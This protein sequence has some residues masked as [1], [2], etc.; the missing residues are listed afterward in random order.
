[1]I[2][3]TVPY[4]APEQI[5]GQEAD[6]R[7]DIFA[8]GA[9][10]Y[11]MVTGQRAFQGKST[12]SLMSSILTINPLAP[13]RVLSGVPPALDHI[14]EQCLA[15]D[16]EERWHSARDLWLELKNAGDSPRA[17]QQAIAP[18]HDRRVWLL[19][20]AVAVLL[21]A[22]SLLAVLYFRAPVPATPSIHF[23]VPAVGNPY[24]LSISPDRRSLAYVAPAENGKSVLWVRA[25]SSLD[26][27]MLPGTE[28]ADVP[29]WSPDSRFIVFGADGK[30]K[31]VDVTG[32]SPQT[33]TNL[34]PGNH[35]R[36]AWNR[37]GV[38]LVANAGI[39][40]RVAA[41]GGELVPVTELDASLGEIFHATPWFL[42]DGRHFFVSGL[43][44]TA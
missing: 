8:F 31:K 3:G 43:E 44:R 36:S 41:D 30:L 12:P 24:Y 7:T 21:V 15:K 40:R 39:L 20:A 35:S 34:V 5:E 37:D 23:E 33:L 6:A 4:M 27:R 29:D 13:S 16:P 25:L 9:V 10:M 32:G 1:M 28:G 2:L 17:S 18:K 14:I 19:G 42:P 11:E 26:A 22:T 38:I